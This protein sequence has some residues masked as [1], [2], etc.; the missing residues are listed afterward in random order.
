MDPFAKK[1]ITAEDLESVSELVER[2]KTLGKG[3]G[4]KKEAA[5]SKVKDLDL[6]QQLI[7]QANTMEYEIRNLFPD[8]PII[9]VLEVAKRLAKEY[10]Q[11]AREKVPAMLEKVGMT[12]VSLST[13]ETV[14]VKQV[15]QASISDKNYFDA[16][17]NMIKQYIADR[18]AEAI[19][20]GTLSEKDGAVLDW[21]GKM[22]EIQMEATESIDAL[23]TKQL[24]VSNPTDK[25]KE[26][27][28]ENDYEYDNKFAIA[29]QTL[30]KYC[31]E[32]LAQGRNIPD[33]ISVFQY[34]EASLK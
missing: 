33:G 14:E 20:D 23:F 2:M 5:F 9:V 30:R 6:R 22:E 13:G 31:T 3:N 18:V 26:L 25:L 16:R 28:L 27:L 8:T 1:T 24:T 11:I 32:Q 21:D 4:F 17:N 10:E 7:G 19:E 29:W 34:N 15:V 12:S